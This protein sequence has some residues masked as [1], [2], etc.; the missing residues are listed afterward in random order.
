MSYT[1]FQAV[2]HFFLYVF[3][4]DFDCCLDIVVIVFEVD[5]HCSFFGT[6]TLLGW[7]ALS[8]DHTMWLGRY[9]CSQITQP[10]TVLPICTNL[11]DMKNKLCSVHNLWTK[12]LNFVNS[13]GSRHQCDSFGCESFAYDDFNP[14]FRFVDWNDIQFSWDTVW[15]RG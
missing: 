6:G 15:T 3:L 8:G 11:Y 13:I 14:T 10:P 4:S 9:G 1:G 7:D 2:F 5:I 12:E